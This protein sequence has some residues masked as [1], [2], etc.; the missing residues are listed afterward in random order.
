[1]V[2]CIKADGVEFICDLEPT[3]ATILVLSM[4]ESILASWQDPARPRWNLTG[5]LTS[6]CMLG[7]KMSTV[8]T[9]HHDLEKQKRLAQEISGNLVVEAV[10][11]PL[12][13]CSRGKV[14]EQLSA[15]M[16]Y[17]RSE[18]NHASPLRGVAHGVV[19]MILTQP[20]DS[21]A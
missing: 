8:K 20:P 6:F 16:K 21:P 7:M 14:A 10:G 3:S 18:I 9:L 17:R 1:M 4:T 11:S 2:E 5:V 13:P 19:P 12:S 15:I